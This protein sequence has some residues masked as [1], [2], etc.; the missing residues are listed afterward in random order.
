MNQIVFEEAIF[1]TSILLNETDATLVHTDFNSVVQTAGVGD[2]VYCDPP[3]AGTF[4]DYACPRFDMDDHERLRDELESAD[5]NQAFFMLSNS[6]VPEVLAMYEGYF[7]TQSERSN[8]V[9]A[10]P[11]DRGTKPDL[12]IRN[13]ENILP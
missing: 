10:N 13:Y 8:S 5:H 11:D 12:I 7:V 6:D 3:Y 2:F 1:G 9:N 4:S